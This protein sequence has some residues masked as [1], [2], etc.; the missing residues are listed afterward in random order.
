[1]HLAAL[2]DTAERDRRQHRCRRPERKANQ[3]IRQH[4]RPPLTV[5]QDVCA[6][7][8]HPDRLT[9]LR[10]IDVQRVPFVRAAGD[11]DMSDGCKRNLGR[12]FGPWLA[13]PEAQGCRPMSRNG[14]A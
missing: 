4:A 7:R 11:S 12:F 3:Q 10:F 8:E 2:Q 1:M 14:R 13:R 6:E 9:Q 5:Q